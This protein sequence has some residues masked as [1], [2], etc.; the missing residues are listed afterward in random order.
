MFQFFKPK[1]IVSGETSQWINACFAWAMA[2]FDGE[3]FTHH[4]VLVQPT[5]Q[6]FPGRVSSQEG[7]ALEVFSQVAAYAGLQHWPFALQPFS[8]LFA[9]APLMLGINTQLRGTPRAA[10]PAI[11]SITQLPVY[12][13]PVQTQKPT[14]LA[15]YFAARVAEHLI[16]QSALSVPGGPDY[17]EMAAEITAVFLGFGVVLANSAYHFKGSCSRCGHPAANRVSALTEAELVYALALF[18][19]YKGVDIKPATQHLKP[20]LKALFKRATAYIQHEHAQ[21][22]LMGT[23]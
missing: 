21:V 14:D 1:P 12:F 5:N 17:F 11:Q 4:G 8:G 9:E 3:T 2:H 7:L 19:A 22:F 15:G 13:H 10:L 6:F 16:L 20:H 23:T 18:C